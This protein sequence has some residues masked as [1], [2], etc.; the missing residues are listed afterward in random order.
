MEQTLSYDHGSMQETENAILSANSQ[1]ASISEEMESVVTS[2]LSECTGP[3][4][5]AFKSA[6]MSIVNNALIE[7]EEIINQFKTNIGN[8]DQSFTEAENTT[9]NTIG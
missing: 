2:K 9:I 3:V 5:E 7:C 8:A 6:Y 4:Y 1:F